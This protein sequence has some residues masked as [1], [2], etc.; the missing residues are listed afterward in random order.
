MQKSIFSVFLTTVFLFLLQGNLF[1]QKANNYDK[2]WTAI[3]KLE[4]D[5][6]TKSALEATEKLYKKIK[7]D[8]NN[9]VQ[10]GQTI[11]S[12]LFIN[13]FQARLEEDGLVKAIYRL[14]E[15]AK[16]AESPIKPILQSMV[17]ELYDRYL[18]NN[19]YKFRNRTK[20]EDFKQEDIRTWDISRIT[21]KCYNLYHASVQFEDTK[22][23]DIDN[24]NA[25]TY[26]GRNVKGLRPTLYDFLVHRAL[27]FFISD[28]YY[29]T[30]PAYKFYLESELDFADAKAFANRD[31]VARD[32][33]SSQFQS[34]ILFQKALLFHADDEDPTAFL[35]L[36]LKRLN[37]VKSKSILV[38][39]DELYLKQ[40]EALKKQFE[41][42]PASAEITHKIAYHYYTQGLKYKPSPTEQ[43]RWDIKKAYELCKDAAEK[44]PKSYGASHCKALMNTIMNKTISLKTEKV[45]SINSPILSLATYRNI[46]KIYLKAIPVTKAQYQN[47][48]SK[49]GEARMK[50]L[51][52][53]AGAYKWSEELKNEG[54]YQI[55]SVEVAVPEL[56]NGRY[57]LAASADE[58]FSYNNNG[59]A[60]SMFFV[61]DMSITSRQENGLYEFYVTD[62]NSGQP[63]HDIKAEFFVSKYNS[64]LRK[65]ET[66]KAHTT[67]SDKDGY[68]KSRDF[69]EKGSY[70][71][72]SYTIKLS[73]HGEVLY[74]DDSYYNN[75]PGSP[76]V[77]ETTSFFLDRAIYRPGQT[78]FF[79][80]LVLSQMTDGKDPKLVANQKRTVEFFDANYQSVA[81]VEVTTNEYGT[82]HGSFITP[83]SGLLGQMRI[84]DNN[85]RSNKY[86]RVEEYKRA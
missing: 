44:H 85:N 51:N 50:F 9:P 3:N 30:K 80:G 79:K 13:K 25:I 42:S 75:R 60:Y 39:K 45:S 23:I 37:F 68:F 31:M 8:N 66:I 28:K 24:Y 63:L 72:N 57:I 65:Y 34:L 36:D 14:E 19:L 5:G 48:S 70:Y 55:H 58:K 83:S 1:A 53:L 6:L 76:Y 29:L 64:L 27:D 61:S 41:S 52:G 21:E 16:N 54:D 7:Q 18:N 47:F 35:D 49:Y 15:E 12:L 32:S 82:F 20:T 71:R 11:K 26:N 38:N 4:Y 22:K 73:R 84:V 59:I 43:Y 33:L 78:V 77:R 81:K 69:K 56:K 17:A 67:T 74:L 46:N 86:L 2:D 40:L 62:R 10:K